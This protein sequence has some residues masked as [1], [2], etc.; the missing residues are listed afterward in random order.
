MKTIRILTVAVVATAALALATPARAGVI[1]VNTQVDEYGTNPAACALREAIEAA[2]TDAD[3]GGLHRGHRGLDTITLPAGTYTLSMPPTPDGNSDGSLD[4]ISDITIDP[5]GV[6]TING[7]ALDRVFTTWSSI[8]FTLSDLTITGEM[9]PD[10]G[11][12]LNA[13]I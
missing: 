2:N 1:A 8:T 7:G 11:A 4:V 10:E 12:I 5:T 9:T 6:V 13:G 3:F